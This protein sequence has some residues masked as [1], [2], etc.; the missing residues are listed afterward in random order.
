[1]AITKTSG[2]LFEILKI[3]SNSRF[4]SDCIQSTS[5]IIR[6]MQAPM[7]ICSLMMIAY[8]YCI[9]ISTGT[10][11]IT[12]TADDTTKIG[13]FHNAISINWNDDNNIFNYHCIGYVDM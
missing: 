4:N 1:M 13:D 6:R 9:L 5:T 11:Y 12:L 3:F 10:D 2:A 7:L 8:S